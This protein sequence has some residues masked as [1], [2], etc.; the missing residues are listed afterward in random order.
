MEC[1][2]NN[3]DGLGP[4]GWLVQGGN[5]GTCLPCAKGFSNSLGFRR[6][7]GNE[8]TTDME[9]FAPAGKAF[10]FLASYLMGGQSQGAW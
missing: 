3:I 1:F 2:C 7:L 10:E 5:R 4:R 9:V 6:S 8:I